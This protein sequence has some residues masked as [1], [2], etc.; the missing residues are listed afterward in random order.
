MVGTV[1]FMMQNLLYTGIALFAPTIVLSNVT[2]MPNWLAIILV[3]LL[4][5]S[6]TAFVS[7]SW[8]GGGEHVV[9]VEDDGIVRCFYWS[10]TQKCNETKVIMLLKTYQLNYKRWIRLV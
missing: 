9:T 8:S 6:Y 1:A 3:A 5:T 4:G 2:G 7:S 10:T